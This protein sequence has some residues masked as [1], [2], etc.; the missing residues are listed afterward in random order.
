MYFGFSE[1]ESTLSLDHS[2]EK[3]R[4]S[5]QLYKHLTDLVELSDKD[6]IEIGSGRGGGLAYIA[7]NTQAKSLLGVDIDKNAVEFSN[8]LHR[9]ANL[10]FLCGNAHKLPLNDDSSDV[11]INVE[12]SHRFPEMERFLSEVTRILK[13]GG[14]FF[15][16][17]FRYHHEW[18][19][20]DALFKRFR[21]KKLE[22]NDITV[23]VRKALEMND[24]RNRA[25]IKRLVPWFMQRVMLNFAGAIGSET[26]ENFLYRRYIYKIYLFEK[27]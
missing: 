18:P 5:I 26:Y 16:T 21:L 13:K 12:S 2:D 11:I 1:P 8:R 3:N 27:Y 22:D 4:Y 23:N 24:H 25:L 14:H 6:I 19:V 7:K 20:T 15:F 17:D 9:A 10:S